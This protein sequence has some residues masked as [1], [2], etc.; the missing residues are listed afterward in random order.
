MPQFADTSKTYLAIGVQTD[1]STVQSALTKLRTT[2]SNLQF[3]AS[4]V[5]SNEIREDRNVT[6]VIRVTSE[7]SGGFDFE[8]SY[9]TFNT[10]FLALLGRNTWTGTGT[11]ASPFTAVN[12]VDKTFLTFERKFEQGAVDSY[13]YFVGCEVDAMTLNFNASEIVTGNCTVMGREAFQATSSLAGTSGPLDSN[14]NRVYNTV[15][16]VNH[17]REGGNAPGDNIMNTVQALTMNITNNKRMSRAIGI[18][19]PASIGDGQFVVTGTLTQY[20]QDN[21][22]YNKFL[23]DTVTSLYIEFDDL[24]NTGNGNR[25]RFNM[26]R[27]VYTNVAREIPGNNQDITVQLDYQAIYDVS[28]DGT[29]QVQRIDAAS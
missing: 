24:S 3:Q 1:D 20:F 19:G 21:A 22:L 6:D 25:I 26:P 27:V 28:I 15:R 7:V 8:L 18:E 23:N 5:Q 12:G 11:I 13:E 14:N 17:L 10:I 16:M 9:D 29:L 2:G 4:N